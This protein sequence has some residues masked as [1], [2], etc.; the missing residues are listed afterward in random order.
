MYVCIIIQC[1][2][3]YRFKGM[4]YLCIKVLNTRDRAYVCVYIHAQSH[5]GEIFWK[6]C[7]LFISM[8]TITNR[9]RQHNDTN[10]IEQ[11]FSYKTLGFFFYY[12]LTPLLSMN[13]YQEFLKCISISVILI[14]FLRCWVHFLFLHTWL[15]MLDSLSLYGLQLFIFFKP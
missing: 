14:L 7:H 5:K 8:E 10:W 2:I 12:A 13:L 15:A 9:Y 6:W 3:K 11:I 1:I 4:L